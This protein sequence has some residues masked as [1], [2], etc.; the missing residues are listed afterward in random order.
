MKIDYPF[1]CTVANRHRF[2][3]KKMK[4]NSCYEELQNFSDCPLYQVPP[5]LT[6]S[7]KSVH[8]CFRYVPNRPTNK[9]THRQTN[10]YENITFAVRRGNWLYLVIQSIRLGNL[11]IVAMHKTSPTAANARVCCTKVTY[12]FSTLVNSVGDFRCAISSGPFVGIEPEQSVSL[13]S[14]SFAIH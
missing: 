4:T 11:A 7:W 10:R 3:R 1:F 2:L 14:I 9:Q 13:T 5:I 12:F 8:T 6:I